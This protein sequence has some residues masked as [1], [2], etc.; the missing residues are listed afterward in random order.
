MTFPFKKFLKTKFHFETITHSR[1]V[2]YLFCFMA[3]LDILYFAN[4]RDMRSIIVLLLVGFLTSFFNKNMIVIIFFALVVTHLLKYGLGPSYY[5]GMTDGVNKL[6]SSTSE[7]DLSDEE[8]PSVKK[9]K[10]DKKVEKKAAAKKNTE[11]LEKVLNDPNI[12]DSLKS[13]YS[14]YHDVQDD[15]VSGIKRIEPLLQKAE[16][17][18]QKYEQ[19]KNIE[20]VQNKKN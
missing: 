18:I 8:P 12:P 5:E 13:S 17:F 10:K 9:D 3:L 15:I 14:D 2:L 7:S 6:D 20:G 1:I 11:D 16:S 4:T 19:Y